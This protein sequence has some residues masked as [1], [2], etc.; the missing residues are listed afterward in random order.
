MQGRRL[1]LGEGDLRPTLQL[2]RVMLE[3]KSLD[4][5]SLGLGVSKECS[6]ALPLRSLDS[7]EDSIDTGFVRLDDVT[8]QSRV[9]Y[10]VFKHG[11]QVIN[12]T[13]G[14]TGQSWCICCGDS[15]AAR[16]GTQ[17]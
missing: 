9:V 7:L 2:N 1:P 5:G 10:C 3:A 17:P 13:L 12:P 14:R 11:L 6:L 8:H 16:T 15:I 4:F